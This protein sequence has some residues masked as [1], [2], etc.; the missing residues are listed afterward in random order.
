MWREKGG[1]VAYGSRIS[2]KCR[3]TLDGLQAWRHY[4]PLNAGRISSSN[5]SR[6]LLH[7]LWLLLKGVDME[8]SCWRT[9]R[10]IDGLMKPFRDGKDSRPYTISESDLVSLSDPYE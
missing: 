7:R 6:M 8:E 4:V 9:H 5:T 2:V 10:I 1:V 3:M